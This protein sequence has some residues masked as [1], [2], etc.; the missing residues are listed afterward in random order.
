MKKMLSILALVALQVS[1]ADAQPRARRT[2]DPAPA[3]TYTAPAARESSTVGGNATAYLGFG[4]GAVNIG[5]EYEA[6]QSANHGFGGYFMFL[7]EKEDVRNQVITFG[8]FVKMHF[9][10]TDAL[11]FYASPGFGIGM[12]DVGDDTET[13]IGPSFRL[14]A[15]YRFTDLISVGW[16]HSFFYNWFNKKV[17]DVG[18]F[19]NVAVRFSF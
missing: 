3:P 14:G 6:V 4:S 7:T 17:A 8:G 19:G 16:E 9:M 5:G 13:T 18:Q 2:A 10:A 15:M 1:V 12:V 11:E